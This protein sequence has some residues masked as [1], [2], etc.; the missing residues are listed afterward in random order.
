[1]S[2]QVLMAIVTSILLW[3]CGEA[4]GGVGGRLNGWWWEV[5]VLWGDAVT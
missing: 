4:V 3:V 5:M 1:M 2:D